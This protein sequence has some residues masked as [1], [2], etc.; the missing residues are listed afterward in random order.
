MRSFQDQLLEDLKDHH[1]D[2]LLMVK[3]KVMDLSRDRPRQ[4][5]IIITVLPHLL[6]RAPPSTPTQGA[7]HKDLPKAS[8]PVIWNSMMKMS[9]KLPVIQKARTL[10]QGILSAIYP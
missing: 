3:A 2:P 4:D 1:L 5:T 10:E 6:L 7:D 8:H 9:K